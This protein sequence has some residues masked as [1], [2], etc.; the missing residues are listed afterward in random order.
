MLIL[1]SSSTAS[2]LVT[3]RAVTCSGDTWTPITASD[4]TAAINPGWNLGNTLDATPD[5]GSWNNPPVVQ[6]T[7]DDVASAG[8][9]SVRIPGKRIHVV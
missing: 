8:F 1:W 4:F 6:A 9:K 3:P 2:A 7:F 5:E